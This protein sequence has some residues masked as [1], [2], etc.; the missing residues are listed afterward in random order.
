MRTI[1]DELAPAV[2]EPE[3][4][5]VLHATVIRESDKALM[6][7]IRGIEGSRWVPKSLVHDDSEAYQAGASGTLMLPTWFV[8]R[9]LR[10]TTRNTVKPAQ[11]LPAELSVDEV[12]WLERLKAGPVVARPCV[13]LVTLERRGKVTREGSGHETR[14][15]QA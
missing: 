8:E 5:E 10:K 3:S 7:A 12:A 9:D 4:H 6:V 14:W 13:A 1:N 11:A 15:V 2:A